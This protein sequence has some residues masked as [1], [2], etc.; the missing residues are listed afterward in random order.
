M[1]NFLKGEDDDHFHE[2][3][4][5]YLTGIGNEIGCFNYDGEFTPLLVRHT[6]VC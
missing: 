3:F 6:L 4:D 1:I 2:F 5:T